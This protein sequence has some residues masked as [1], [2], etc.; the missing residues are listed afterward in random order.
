MIKDVK[1]LTGILLYDIFKM[2]VLTKGFENKKGGG[3]KKYVVVFL[4]LVLF[5]GTTGLVLAQ[6]GGE[7]FYSDQ[8][9]EG[10]FNLGVR[11]GAVIPYKP[12]ADYVYTAGTLSLERKNG[13]FAGGEL[14][15]DLGDYLAVGVEG[16]YQQYKVDLTDAFSTMAA[17]DNLGIARNGMAF[18]K[19]IL[20]Y[21]FD[22]GDYTFTP[23]IAAAP[24][25]IFPD[26]KE[27]AAA[28][29]NNVTVKPETGFAAKYSGG[30]DLCVTDSI[31]INVEGAFLD[32]D[33]KT[34]IGTIKNDIKNDAWMAGGGLKYKF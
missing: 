12:K 17:T 15:Y 11:G 8:E 7:F 4:G 34:A 19:F 10:R 32:V 24:G 31:A 2:E 29:T 9:I 6:E 5:F 13:W 27:S 33:I 1:C 30:F 20:K 16:Y 26:F 3:M 23:Y 21:G 25:G 28:N 14:S 22:M 18:G